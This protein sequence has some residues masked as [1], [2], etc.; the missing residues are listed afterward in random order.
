MPAET[1]SPEYWDKREAILTNLTI[2]GFITILV[3][4]TFGFRAFDPSFWTASDASLILKTL[5]TVSA[6]IGIAGA[7]LFFITGS[8]AAGVGAAEVRGRRCC[9]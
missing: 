5:T 1:K 8:S 3:G 2:T 6:A 7:I 9:R 4:F